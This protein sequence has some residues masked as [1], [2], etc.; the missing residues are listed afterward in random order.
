[1]TPALTQIG[2]EPDPAVRLRQLWGRN[3][4]RLR[5]LRGMTRA[6]LA[7]A[8]NVS[9]AAIGQ[10]ERGE[11]T[12]RPHKQIAAAKALDAEHGVVFPMVAA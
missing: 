9:E 6:Q 12:P 2:T 5:E 10:W 7:E 11:T 8:C 3:I 1:M 4:K